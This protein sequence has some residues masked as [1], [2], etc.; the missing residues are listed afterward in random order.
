MPDTRTTGDG[1]DTKLTFECVAR[2]QP[3]RAAGLQNPPY[4][5]LA[6]V[7]SRIVRAIRRL[8]ASIMRPS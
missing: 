2:L 3:R 1:T 7:R 6:P 4:L 5:L 8:A